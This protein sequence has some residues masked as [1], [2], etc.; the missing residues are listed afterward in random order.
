MRTSSGQE[1]RKVD[2]H[3]EQNDGRDARPR[4]SITHT[5]R[6]SMK[7]IC[8]VAA[9]M[10]L[11]AWFLPDITVSDSSYGYFYD[12]LLMYGDRPPCI[13]LKISPNRDGYREKPMRVLVQDQSPNTITD[14]GVIFTSP[15]KP[16]QMPRSYLL[17][18]GKIKKSLRVFM[19]SAFYRVIYGEG[20]VSMEFFDARTCANAPTPDEETQRALDRL[21]EE[22]GWS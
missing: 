22:N 14:E 6:M 19:R 20:F 9:G 13:L 4:M 3:P 21:V 8:L 5:E 7:K 16:R 12:P 18:N 1:Q 17:C 2:A 11:V 15:P 10:L